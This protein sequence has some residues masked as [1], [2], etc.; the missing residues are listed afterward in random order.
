MRTVLPL[1]SL[2]LAACSPDVPPGPAPG[3][4]AGAGKDRLCIAGAG[5]TLRAGLIAYAAHGAANCS[6]AGKLEQDG[7][8]WTVTPRG[9]GDCRIGLTIAEDELSIANVPASCSYY[10][11]PGAS[12]AGKSFT[13]VSEASPAA[14]LAG[15][16]LC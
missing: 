8:G 15:E 11:G 10:C 5:E 16:A 7:T 9:D 4:F 14:D 13:R 2:F 3:T 12:L 1:L 6:V